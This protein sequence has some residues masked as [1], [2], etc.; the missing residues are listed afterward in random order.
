M[1]RRN[2]MITT[3]GECIPYRETA[4]KIHIRAVLAI[5][6]ALGAASAGAQPA[7]NSVDA[8]LAAAKAAA[9]FDFTGTL[10]RV[11]IAPQTGPGRDVAPGPAPARAT[12][13]TEPAKV[14]DNLYFRGP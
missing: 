7:A 10:A 11:C 3:S 5:M 1:L 14:F 12:W 8:H 6:A 9:E 2:M 13:V 4:M